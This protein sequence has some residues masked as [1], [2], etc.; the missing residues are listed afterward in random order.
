MLRRC[1][2]SNRGNAKSKSTI[3]YA[4]PITKTICDAC[5]VKP[6]NRTLTGAIEQRDSPTLCYCSSLRHPFVLFRLCF[7]ALSLDGTKLPCGRYKMRRN[8]PSIHHMTVTERKCSHYKQTK[9]NLIEFNIQL[10]DE[11]MPGIPNTE[12]LSKEI[13]SPGFTTT[14]LGHSKNVQI[15]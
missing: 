15:I 5:C 9:L 6:Q 11:N 13:T 12:S 3:V 8:S 1:W 4:Y 7:L 2:R 10:A 14:T